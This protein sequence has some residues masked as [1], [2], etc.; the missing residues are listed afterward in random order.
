MS[1]RIAEC[2]PELP[3]VAQHLFHIFAKIHYI[4]LCRLKS[5][6]IAAR[7]WPKVGL[8]HDAQIW[9]SRVRAWGVFQFAAFSGS[10][11]WNHNWNRPLHWKLSWTNE[12]PLE[13]RM[14]T[15][16]RHPHHTSFTP[17][18]WPIKLQLFC[19][20]EKSFRLIRKNSKISKRTIWLNGKCP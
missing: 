17:I 15:H 4:A 7:Q 8:W 20:L 14:H 19:R 6:T 9:K 2:R 1:P 11:G 12:S 13:V 16:S 5:Q 10:A 3:N 18:Y